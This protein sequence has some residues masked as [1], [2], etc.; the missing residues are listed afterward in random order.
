MF[1]RLTRKLEEYNENNNTDWIFIFRSNDPHM[2]SICDRKDVAIVPN[3]WPNNT[4][5]LDLKSALCTIP[6]TEEKPIFNIMINEGKKVFLS[7]KITKSKALYL[8]AI[9]EEEL[10]HT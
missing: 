10:R 7:K 5:E 4:I 9:I 3:W 1:Y 8:S 2:V 6:T